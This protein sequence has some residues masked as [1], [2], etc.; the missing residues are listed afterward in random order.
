MQRFRSG[1]LVLALLPGLLW[2][3][4]TGWAGLGESLWLDELHTAWTIKPLSDPVAKPASGGDLTTLTARAAAGN[5]VPTY[6]YLLRTFDETLCNGDQTL[7]R[8]VGDGS[9]RSVGSGVLNAEVRLRLP[10]LVAWLLS[11]VL[12]GVVLRRIPDW[13]PICAATLLTAVDR[14]SLFYGTEARPYYFVALINL[15]GWAALA[16]WL[17]RCNDRARATTLVDGCAQSHESKWLIILGWDWWIWTAAMVVSCRLHPVAILSVACQCVWGAWCL[18][19]QSRGTLRAR[20]LQAWAAAC[21]AAAL[22]LLPIAWSMRSVWE[23]RSQWNAFASDTSWMQTIS[24]FALIPLF[25]SLVPCILLD[26]AFGR[27]NVSLEVDPLADR[28]VCDTSRI[29]GRIWMIACFGPWILAWLLTTAGIAPLM[30]RRYLITCLLPLSVLVGLGVAKIGRRSLRRVAL[31]VVIVVIVVYQGSWQPWRRGELIGLQRGENWRDAVAYVSE[32]LRRVEPRTTSQSPA[33]V[34]CA[35]GLIEAN[36]AEWP[37]TESL[38]EYL[39]FPLRGT[40]VVTDTETVDTI[41]ANRVKL[42]PLLNRTEAWREEWNA[43]SAAGVDEGWIIYRGSER[44]LRARF[45]EASEVAKNQLQRE[46]M[47]V[48]SFGRVT[49]AKWRRSAASER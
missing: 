39:T 41:G 47:D 5:Q 9:G 1:L 24:L 20:H 10:S 31:A 27:P 16:A 12:L 43:A 11:I 28:C 6:F 38:A 25:C 23:H 48:R 22:L 13:A 30:H 45:K 35:A 36:D 7:S 49:V 3:L 17:R 29:D 19:Q 8:P 15:L 32:Q 44:G 2:A 21:T 33:H 26:L 37:P 4:V 40:Y 34:W 18:M 42:R 14:I 46:L